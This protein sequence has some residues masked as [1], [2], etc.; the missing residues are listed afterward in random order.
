MWKKN[1]S[2]SAQGLA[3]GAIYRGFSGWSFPQ[4]PWPQ[5]CCAQEAM[6]RAR[7]HSVC[8]GKCW[9]PGVCLLQVTRGF[10]FHAAFS[11]SSRLFEKCKGVGSLYWPRVQRQTIKVG[12]ACSV[13]DGDV[14]TFG[15]K[16]NFPLLLYSSQG[17]TNYFGCFLE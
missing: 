16:I 7:H 2:F 12:G 17:S 1:V 14:S 6:F 9:S 3:T 15:L 11:F 5:T 4:W 10:L 8:T 13:L